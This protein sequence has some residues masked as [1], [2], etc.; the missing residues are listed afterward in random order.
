MTSTASGDKIS[1]FTKNVPSAPY[2]VKASFI[3][4]LS[5]VQVGDF[6][7]G[8]MC[9]YDG[10]K[11]VLFGILNIGSGR[12]ALWAVKYVTITTFSADYLRVPLP[13]NYNPLT[14][15]I[16]D[17]NTDRT[18]SYS[19]DGANFIPVHKVSRTDF[20]TPTKIGMFVGTNADATYSG[21]PNIGSLT[22]LSWEEA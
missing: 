18:L 17:D 15:K 1:I 10:T 22:W 5:S 16:A 11:L 14:L 21:V 4:G 19:N 2:S 8:G 6:S 20:L 3:P 12:P 13:L 9:L 7:Y